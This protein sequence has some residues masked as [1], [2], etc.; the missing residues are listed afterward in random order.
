MA[1]TVWANLMGLA[2]RDAN[3]E[4]VTEYEYEYEYE[5]TA[6]Q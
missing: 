3:K 6:R 2:T 1:C 5:Y 4:E